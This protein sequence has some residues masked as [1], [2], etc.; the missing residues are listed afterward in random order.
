MPMLVIVIVIV[1]VIENYP[2]KRKV[3]SVQGGLGWGCVDRPRLLLKQIPSLNA[4]RKVFDY[5]YYYEHE[6]DYPRVRTIL[7]YC[8]AHTVCV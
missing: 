4:Y 1:I 7:Y 5:D 3:V 2:F 8:S 6:H